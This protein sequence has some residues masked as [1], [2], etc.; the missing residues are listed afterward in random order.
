M[1][2]QKASPFKQK[3]ASQFGKG[4]STVRVPNCQLKPCAE[5]MILSEEPDGKSLGHFQPLDERR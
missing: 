5:G 2:W 3:L 4:Y 1:D